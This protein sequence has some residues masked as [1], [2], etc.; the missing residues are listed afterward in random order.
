MAVTTCSY[1][2]VVHA[3][4]IMDWGPAKYFGPMAHQSLNSAL[5]TIDLWWKGF[6]EKASFGRFLFI[7]LLV[8]A[9]FL[10]K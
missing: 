9:V 7:V 1:F 6:A 8:S 10:D 4:C 5:V 3:V 2:R